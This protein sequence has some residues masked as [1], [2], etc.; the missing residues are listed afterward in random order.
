VALA[1]LKDKRSVLER[2]A[3]VLLEKEKIDHD[4]IRGLMEGA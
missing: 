3:R 4:E 1:I 2:G